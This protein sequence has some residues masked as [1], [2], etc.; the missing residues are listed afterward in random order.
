MPAEPAIRELI[1]RAALLQHRFG[2]E[3]GKRPMVLPNGKFF[4]DTFTPDEASVQ[5]LLGRMRTLAGLSDVPIEA[6]VLGLATKGASGCGCGSSTPTA[7]SEPPRKRDCA[8]DCGGKGCADCDGSCHHSKAE[9]GVSTPSPG[10]SSCNTGCS[11]GCGTGPGLPQNPMGDDPRLIDLGN[12]WRIQIPAAEV[13]H[14]VAL[15]TNLATALGVVFLAETSSPKNPTPPPLELSAEILSCLLGFGSL[16]L[17]GSYVYQK[18][19]GGPRIGRLTALGPFELGLATV[20]FARLQGHDLRPLLRELEVTQKDAVQKAA[21]WLAERPVIVERFIKSPE[22]LAAGDVPMQ[23]E[24][25]GLFSRL[26]GSKPRN[27]TE[28]GDIA[29]LEALLEK[30]PRTQSGGAAR[31]AD[32]KRDELRALVDEALA[33]PNAEQ[34]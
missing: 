29:E 25:T 17:A 2:T 21:D 32:P 10:A 27:L 34:P 20:L 22:R 24:K 4:P 6:K 28:A 31:R 26:F 3:I 33:N 5:K 19:C 16:A 12:A 30:E 23:V 8:G 11:T 13:G 1:V 9:E 14:P 15:T 18:S 7:D